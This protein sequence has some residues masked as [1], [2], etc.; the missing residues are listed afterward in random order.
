[1][2]RS[3]IFKTASLPYI[4][5]CLH[6]Y[7]RY[8]E[9]IFQRHLLKEQYMDKEKAIR[10]WDEMEK[11]YNKRAE[12]Y[13]A[14]YMTKYMKPF[15]IFGNLYYIGDKVICLHMVD[16]GEGLILFDTGF[17]HVK[18]QYLEN[19]EILGYRPEDIRYIIHTHEHFDHFGATYDLQKKFGC[20]TFINKYA[21]EVFRDR[22]EHTEIQSC[23]VPDARI[24]EPDV[25]LDD[26]DVVE[27]GNTSVRCIH[28]PGHSA[29][30]MSFIFK[31]TDGGREL[32]AGICGIGGFVTLHTGRLL[33][34]GIDLS[35]RQDYIRSIEKLKGEEVDIMLDT[36]PR[37]DGVIRRVDSYDPKS[38][39]D[40]FIDRDRWN[41]ALD[42]YLHRFKAFMQR[43]ASEEKEK[44]S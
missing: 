3:E 33:K 34:Y 9:Y 10:N 8:G 14:D 38:L 35:A 44:F 39:E 32:T 40:L 2:D 11:A 18:T 22:P 30:S 26:G 43:E 4:S 21:A 24:F 27:L 15:R 36:H 19:I 28:N 6:Y 5:P 16:T 23:G 37:P 13:I 41:N 42:E 1:M 25:E 29:G 17:P 20:R 7:R 12:P 31:V